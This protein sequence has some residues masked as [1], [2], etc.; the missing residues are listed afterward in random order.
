MWNFKKRAFTQENIFNLEFSRRRCCYT[1]YCVTQYVC[2]FHS[3]SIKIQ[4][5]YDTGYPICWTVFLSLRLVNL[6]DVTQFGKKFDEEKLFS[7]FIEFRQNG[8]KMENGHFI[9]KLVKMTFSANG[10]SHPTLTIPISRKFRVILP[11]NLPLPLSIK[12]SIHFE[13]HMKIINLHEFVAWAYCCGI[14]KH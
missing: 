5:K 14:S 6:S 1:A 4:L 10:F 7:E 12:L 13:F 3:H 8:N 9:R 11:Q 2:C